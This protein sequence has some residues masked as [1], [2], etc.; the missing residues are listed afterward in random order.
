MML[1]W[2]DD[3]IVAASDME[4][5]HD[6]KQMLQEK[7]HMKDLGRL[8]YFLGI[9]FEQWNG[10]VKMN[11]RHYLCKVL[12]KFEM[13]NCKPRATPSEQK[14]NFGS[15][16]PFDP[17]RYCEV[18]GS[19]IYVMTCTR[20]NI[21]WIVTRLFQFL[22][23]PLQEHWIAAMH[24]LTYLK[25]TLDYELCYRK[26]DGGLTLVGYSDADWPSSSDDRQY[27]LVGTVSA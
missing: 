5:L 10:F 12:E 27:L 26:C 20:P 24:V 13:K 8:S 21:C 18:V 9:N 6:T 19:L 7:F 23:K 16:T 11:Q 15:K 4:L 2:V 14:L 22:S 25:G 17:R 3:F 1:K